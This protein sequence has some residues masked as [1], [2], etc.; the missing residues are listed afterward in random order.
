MFRENPKL[1]KK[2]FA[3]WTKSGKISFELLET[4]K[5]PFVLKICW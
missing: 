2:I 5:R 1:T 3:G 4:K